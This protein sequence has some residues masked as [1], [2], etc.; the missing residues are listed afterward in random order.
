MKNLLPCFVIFFLFSSCKDKKEVLPDLNLLEVNVGDISLSDDN[1]PTEN[2]PIDRSI[3]IRFSQSLNPES[4][5]TSINLSKETNPVNFTTNLIA[6]NQ[7]IVISPVGVLETGSTY[8]LNISNELKAA[9]GAQFSGKDFS[10]K[11]I[12]GA[13]E[14]N[15]FS[16]P[17]SNYTNTD[18]TENAPVNFMAELTFN[19]PVDQNTVQEAISLSGPTIP[20]LQFSYAENG[21][22]IT[23]TSN[24]PL[25]FI[26]KYTLSVSNKLKGIQGENFTAFAKDFYTEVDETPKLPIISDQELLTKVQAQTFR[27]F[28]DF[29]HETSGLARERNTSGNTVT[30][31]GSGFGVMSLIV[32]VKRG[33]ISRDQAVDR[34]SK[35]VDFLIDADRF[36]GVWPHWMNGETGKTIPFSNKDNGGD[37]VETAFM[38]QG[39]LTVKAYL[40]PNILDEKIIIDKITQLWETV[41][42]DWYTKENSGVLYWHWSPNYNWEM[43]LPI[44]GY[45]E[46]LIVYVLAASSPTHPI[47]K[48]I[49]ENG[50]AKNGDIQNGSS[51]YG[52]QLPLGNNFGGPLFF[53]HYSFLGLDPRNLSDQYANYWTQNVQH[54]LIN[55]A[56]CVQNPQGFIGYSETSWGLT[57][58]DN[59][60]GY[61]AHSPTNDKGVITPTAALSSF[62]YAPEESMK[63]L[64]YFYYKLGDKI[65]GDYGFYD[66]YNITESWYADSYLA[67][68]QGPVIIMI[69]NYRSALLWDLFM[70]DKDVQSGLNKLEFSY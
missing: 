48:S 20:S 4:V 18:R 45:N 62:P 61:S 17:E 34:W 2:I 19:K 6:N 24:S 57:A 59:H 39:L 58:S 26:S 7:T 9:S 13:L 35:I 15:S 33:F 10:F 25:E 52:L 44:R 32:G 22:K 42:W 47:D 21:Q 38:I 29:A 11:T 43:N 28:W 64:H 30:I 67:I 41:E 63:A 70:S 49:Y 12:L 54:T 50:W 60:E 55:Q 27:Y 68:D 40:N 69:E 51:Y 5:S 37:L 56:H 53:A 36:H 31:G 65:W 66:A 16:I 3:S 1:T 14:M 8:Q 46:A 23:I